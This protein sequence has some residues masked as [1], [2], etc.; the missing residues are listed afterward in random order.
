MS[1]LQ[2]LTVL[3][4]TFNEQENI[5]RTLQSLEWAPRIL[6]IDSGS[7]DGTLGII[8]GHENVRVIQR[9]FVDFADQCNFGLSEVKTP[10][11]L[12]IDADYVF[13]ADSASEIGRCLERGGAYQAEFDYCIYGQPVRGSILPPRTVLYRKDQARYENDGHG[14][15][16]MV[17]DS[18]STLA[19]RIRHDD[20]KPLSRWLQSQVPY[21]RQEAQKL[22]A[23]P[24]KQLGRN[25]RI[26][27]LIVL[28][29]P[30]VFMLVYV[31]RGGFLSGWR[32]LYYALQR[33]TAESLLSLFLIDKRLTT[34]KHE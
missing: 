24:R 4:I 10:W 33:T 6:V 12:S 34:R 30:L 13:P 22:L 31:L 29:P 16:V 26:R 14:H 32:G 25:D 23:T 20:C 7:T 28:A 18:V 3:I 19:F 17:Q 21:A 15:R 2:Q 27:R 5:G 9:S 1:A 8:Q 11:V